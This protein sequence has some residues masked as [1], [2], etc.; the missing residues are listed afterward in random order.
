MGDHMLGHLRART[1]H[2]HITPKHI[3]KLRQF[4]ELPTAQERPDRSEALVA[5]RGH[6]MMSLVGGQEHGPEFEYGKSAAVKPH[7]LLP[8]ERRPRGCYPHSYRDHQHN[9]KQHWKYR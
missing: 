6:L 7:P 4:I 5:G 2:T 8:K 1:H 3:E 9:R